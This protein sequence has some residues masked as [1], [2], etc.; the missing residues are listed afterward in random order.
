M[1]NIP[2]Q[3]RAVDP[4]ASY[5][6]NVVNQLTRMNTYKGGSV[7]GVI[8]IQPDLQVTL[9]STSPLYVV[10]VSRGIA[11]KDDVFIRVSPAHT[12][13]F[14]DSDNYVDFGTGFD[15][16]GYYYIVLEYNYV[17]S[18]PAPECKIKIIKPT[19]RGNFNWALPSSNDFIFLK[20]VNVINYM[21]A[22]AIDQD[23]ATNLFDVDPEDSTAKRRYVRE[24]AGAEASLPTF[25]ASRDQS[26]LVYDAETDKFWFGYSDRW[27]EIGSGGS[28]INLNTSG[29]AEGDLCYADST[30]M[31]ALAISTSLVTCADVVVEEVGVSGKGLTSGI[32]EDVKVETAVIVNAGDLL[33]LSA[34]T[35][36]RV[37]NVRPEPVYQVVGRA[38]TDGDSSNPIDIIFSPKVPLTVGIE[39]RITTWSGPSS[40]LYYKNIDVSNLDTS[41]GLHTSWYNDADSTEVQPAEV[42]LISGGATLRVYFPINTLVISYLISSQASSGFGGL[43]GGSGSDHSLLTNLSYASSGHTGFAPSPHGNAH[44]SSTY[45]TAGGVTFTNLNANGDVGTG[46]AQVAVGD[47]SHGGATG[48]I[49]VGAILLF[50]SNVALTGYTLLTG[51]DDET[52]FISKGAGSVIGAGGT[53]TGTWNQSTYPHSHVINT[54]ATHTHSVSSHNH[55]IGTHTHSVTAPPTQP[56]DEGVLYQDGLGEATVIPLAGWVTAAASGNTGYN[57]ATAQADGSHDHGGNTDDSFTP[58]TWRPRGRIF[59]RQQKT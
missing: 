16:V 56:E 31:A 33:Y 39:G 3:T 53:S 23:P 4:F 50:E 41:F 18:R 49:P 37:T 14:R 21:S 28:V 52:V 7:N 44:H 58:I 9:D 26:R 48:G 17:K 20:A 51:I 19:Q 38:L 32:A 10:S 6:S 8:A 40:G 22:Q 11:Y 12:V 30:A 15:E 45:I 55:P 47:H 35:A 57:G 27:A 5:N 59:T 36:G 54:E 43:G 13:D 25:S 24:Y 2:A 34:L 29:M 42:Q 46:A 1:S